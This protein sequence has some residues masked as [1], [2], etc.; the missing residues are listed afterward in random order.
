MKPGNVSETSLFSTRAKPARDGKAGNRK[1][2]DTTLGDNVDLSIKGQSAA[3][4]SIA[5]YDEAL[6]MLKGLDF[7]Q[8]ADAHRIPNETVGMLVEFLQA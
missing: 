5:S 6:D 7:R 4:S 1:V 2:Q 8:A 3:S